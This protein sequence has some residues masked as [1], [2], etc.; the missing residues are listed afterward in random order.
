MKNKDIDL[1]NEAYSSMYEE[2]KNNELMFS[3][4]EE[5][6]LGY[7]NT[8][9]GE[10]YLDDEVFYVE[11]KI[12]R[13]SIDQSDYDRD[14]GYGRSTVPGEL[15]EEEIEFYTVEKA[16]SDEEVDENTISILKSTIADEFSK[17]LY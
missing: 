9:S 6:E 3:G 11:G 1:I 5:D 16:N 7:H 10:V 17:G 8:F 4:A 2:D 15:D 13:E 14:T 12:R